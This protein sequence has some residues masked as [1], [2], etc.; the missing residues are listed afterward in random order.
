MQT[1]CLRVSSPFYA[2]CVPAENMSNM[3]NIAWTLTYKGPFKSTTAGYSR[4]FQSMAAYTSF[5][6]INNC[7]QVLKRPLTLI[8]SHIAQTAQ[9]RLQCIALHLNNI[10][11]SALSQCYTLLYKAH[12]LHCSNRPTTLSGRDLLHHMC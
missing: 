8:S 2:L 12:G 10:S 7:F 4:L 1:L 9:P 5:Q 11:S 6:A 3:T